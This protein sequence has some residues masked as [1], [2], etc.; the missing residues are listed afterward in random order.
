MIRAIWSWNEMIAADD[1]DVSGD[2]GDKEE[3]AHDIQT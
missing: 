3:D 2:H 1:D